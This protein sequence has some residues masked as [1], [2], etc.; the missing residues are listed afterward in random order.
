VKPPRMEVDGMPSPNWNDDDELMLDLRAAL[1]A[2]A[3][4]EQVLA[5]ARAAFAWRTVD[6]DLELIG[7][8]YDSHLEDG[9]LV[10][11][12]PTESPRTL[13]FHGDNLGVE[14]ELNDGGIEG[15]LIPA[16]PG[17][18]TLVTADGPYAAAAADPVGCFSFP[19]PPSGP[20]R[21]ECSTEAGRF[22]TVWITV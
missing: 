7:L 2:P 21:L 20:I 8:L 19:P 11:E 14:I 6:A 9:S 5:A 3:V 1:R 10:R 17:M 13:A 12:S 22:V 18:V 15:Q 16:Q 4:D